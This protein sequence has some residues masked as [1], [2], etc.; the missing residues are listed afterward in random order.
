MTLNDWNYLTFTYNGAIKKIYLNGT[1]ITSENATGNITTGAND[2]ILGYLGTAMG[3]AIDDLRI[4]NRALPTPEIT[5][6]YNATKLNYK[7]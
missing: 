4:Y 5:A 6:L 2:L 7:R 3:G 1:E